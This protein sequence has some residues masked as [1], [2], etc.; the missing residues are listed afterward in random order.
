[1]VLDDFW[2][3]KTNLFGN[4]VSSKVEYIMLVISNQV[5]VDGS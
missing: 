1:M 5:F 3:L 2:N 4:E